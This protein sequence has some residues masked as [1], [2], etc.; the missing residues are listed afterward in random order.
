MGT[1]TPDRG[2]RASLEGVQVSQDTSSSGERRSSP[3][4]RAVGRITE[5]KRCFWRKPVAI[6]GADLNKHD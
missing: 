1:R 5:G 2:L 6:I 4:P 3:A